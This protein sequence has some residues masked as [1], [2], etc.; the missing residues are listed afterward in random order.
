MK[1]QPT[2]TT[3]RLILR[4]Y[5]LA[6][7]K[8]LQRLIG[9]RAVADTLLTVPHPYLDG[10]AEDWI[11]KRQLEFEENKSVMLAITDRNQG[12]LIG[13]IGFTIFSEHVK[14][15][16]GYWIGKPHWHQGYCTEAA[17]TMLK[18]GFETLGL[19]LIYATHMTRNPR[20]GNVM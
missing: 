15:E 18:Y 8:D 14:A 19:N 2:L 13:G 17:G 20:S 3:A 10:M 1:D 11:S 6:D 16:I 7:A 12:F 5:S 9:D 4:P